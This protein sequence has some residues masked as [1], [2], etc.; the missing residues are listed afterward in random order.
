MSSRTLF[1]WII[2]FSII[3][4]IILALQ[5]LAA[6][7]ILFS[8]FCFDSPSPVSH[9]TAL[10]MFERTHRN[11]RLRSYRFVHTTVSVPHR[12][13]TE[14]ITKDPCVTA[15]DIRSEQKYEIKNNNFSTLGSVGF[16]FIFT[17]Q[18]K[19]I[20]KKVISH[21]HIQQKWQQVLKRNANQER[22][23]SLWST[24]KIW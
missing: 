9:S 19:K 22:D 15:S 17:K 1:V 14:C 10:P 16:R 18:I 8:C 6:K 7:L 3:M 23:N 21:S 24:K 2:C 20:R 5:T 4:I 13:A 11:A 12:K